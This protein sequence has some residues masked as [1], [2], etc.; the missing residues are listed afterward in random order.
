MDAKSPQSLPPV[1][2]LPPGV[3]PDAW[4]A[5]WPR[6]KR[7]IEKTEAR[8]QQRA[9]DASAKDARSAGQQATRS[10]HEP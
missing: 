2:P 1:P 10:T 5:G 9:Q 7:W 8:I 4:R 6:M 3:D